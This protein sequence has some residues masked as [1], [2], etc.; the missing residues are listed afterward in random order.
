MNGESRRYNDEF[1]AYANWKLGDLLPNS[2]LILGR[3]RRLHDFPLVLWL[4]ESDVNNE[5]R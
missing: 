2:D 3:I 1:H 4:W 5:D